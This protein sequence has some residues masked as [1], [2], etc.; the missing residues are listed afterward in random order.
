[1][2]IEDNEI[3][4]RESDKNW[5]IAII[6]KD[7]RIDNYT[8]SVSICLKHKKRSIQ[9]SH[10]TLKSIKNIIKLHILTHRKIEKDI[11]IKKLVGDSS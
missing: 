9:V 8:H 11:L 6:S 7:I 4:I 5:S 1:M 2:K 3:Y 10:E